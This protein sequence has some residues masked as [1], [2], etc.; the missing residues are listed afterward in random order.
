MCDEGKFVYHGLSQT[1]LEKLVDG[2]FKLE[3]K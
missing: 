3:G 2:V 1:K